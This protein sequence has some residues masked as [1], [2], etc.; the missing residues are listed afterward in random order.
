MS[1]PFLCTCAYCPPH[2]AALLFT[3][4]S[5][6]T[7]G[8][9]RFVCAEFLLRFYDWFCG[10]P[11]CLKVFFGV[12]RRRADADSCRDLTALIEGGDGPMY[13]ASDTLHTVCYNN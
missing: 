12:S 8:C 9:G 7:I 2:T 4:C 5:Q 11:W 1:S 6:V 3:P 10:A 13:A